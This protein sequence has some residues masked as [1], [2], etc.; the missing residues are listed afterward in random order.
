MLRRALFLLTAAL[1]VAGEIQDPAE[2]DAYSD[3]YSTTNALSR[4]SLATR[5]LDRFP[6]SSITAPVLEAAAK[7]SIELGDGSA[8]VYYAKRSLQIYL[9][10]PLLLAPL[11]AVQAK[12]GEKAAA[13]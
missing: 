11:A 7:A 5:F 13:K 12:R 8:A 9:E 3:I 4:R 6:A 2:R 1:A 10:N